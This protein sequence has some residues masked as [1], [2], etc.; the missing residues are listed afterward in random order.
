MCEY[1]ARIFNNNH[2]FEKTRQKCIQ[3]SLDLHNFEQF[4]IV[5]LY[6]VLVYEL[7]SLV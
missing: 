1:Y 5:P 7:F 2:C 4:G 3:I 6:R